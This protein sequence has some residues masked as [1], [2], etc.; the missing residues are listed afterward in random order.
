LADPAAI[1]HARPWRLAAV[2][3]LA[4]LAAAALMVAMAGQVS[5][6][7]M[8][9]LQG[10]ALAVVVALAGVAVAQ[11][12]RLRLLAAAF[13]NGRLARMVSDP[14]G[15]LVLANDRLRGLLDDSGA[16]ALAGTG[17]D[18]LFAA[19]P[20]S[21]IRLQSMMRQALDGDAVADEVPLSVPGRPRRW[22]QVQV[23]G[24]PAAGGVLLWSLEDVHTRR[25][26][27]EIVREEQAKLVDFMDHAPIGFYSVDREG[28][29]LYVNNTLARWLECRPSDLIDGGLRLRDLIAS[30]MADAW[31]ALPTGIEA[32]ENILVGLLGRHVHVAITQAA[33]PDETGAVGQMR[34]ALRDLTPEREWQAALDRSRQRFQ[35][36]FEDAPNGIALVEG[37][38]V[39][40]EA[41]PALAR[42]AGRPV[43]GLVG[44][45]VDRLVVAEDRPALHEALARLRAGTER[46]AP[47]ELHMAGGAP[48]VIASVH[49]RRLAGDARSTGALILHFIDV[50][51]RKTLEQQFVQSQKMQA[52]GQLAGGIA[53][54]F[55]NLLTAIGGFCDLLLQRHRPGDRSFADIMQ[56]RQNADRAANLVRQLLAFSRQQTLKPRILDVTNVIAELANLIRRLIG[57]S[58]R[59]EIHHGRDLGLVRV[60]VGQ[61]EQVIINLAVN[62]RD[63]MVGGGTLTIS[64][65]PAHLD[66]PEWRGSEMIPAGDYVCVTVADTGAGIAPQ[67]L[68]RIFE[69][70]FSTKAPGAGTGLGLSTVYGIVRQTGG[71]VFVDSAPG[72][73]A[74]FTLFLPAQHGVA[75]E[76]VRVVDDARTRM[77]VDLTGT[78]TI[79]LAED[80]AAVRVFGARALRAKGYTVLE[81]DTGEEALALLSAPDAP[82]VDLLVT[83][84]VM[85]GLDG[86]AL[87]TAVRAR[88]PEMKVIF[89]SGYAEDKL[90]QGLENGAEGTDMFLP[91]P[92]SLKQLAAAVKSMLGSDE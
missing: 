33:V 66:M 37:N 38:D 55:N 88:W 59:L 53:H 51:E 29:F 43:A 19:D 10:V 54:D 45:P 70:F 85:P 46:V 6:L 84:V 20:E 69:P 4:G 24:L 52:V 23:S 86:P 47:V 8:L 9:L 58:I 39:L 92:F 63:A 72:L 56:I 36:F 11:N 12:A 74:R 62:A 32:G 17:V 61:L 26:L 65:A 87:V 15:R 18:V 81:A 34:A 41:N 5:A 40:S 48:A 68:H 28:Y 3:A 42:L 60:D 64:T 76:E 49:A 79:L 73:G 44:A 75:A 16:E 22:Y 21:G 82:K 27:E 71:F 83:D 35:R 90:R 1:P 67:N 57:E 30:P 91:K 31:S 13:E 7:Q 14:E 50:S 80:E 89:I 2:L 78:S 77:P 25:G